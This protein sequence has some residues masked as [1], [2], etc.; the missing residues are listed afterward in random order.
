MHGLAS[1]KLQTAP[2]DGARSLPS[3]IGPHF[4]PFNLRILGKASYFSSSACFARPDVL[5]DSTIRFQKS[6]PSSNYL[7]HTFALVLSTWDDLKG[8]HEQI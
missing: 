3:T 1:P 6:P 7:T 2:A 5:K 4:H 8:K